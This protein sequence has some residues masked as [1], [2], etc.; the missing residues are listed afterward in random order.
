M[1]KHHSDFDCLNFLHS[2]RTINE[3]ESYKKVC[4]NKNFCNIFMLSEDTK[5]LEF[6]Q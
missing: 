5:M 6:N 1:L 3:L 2:F 4:E